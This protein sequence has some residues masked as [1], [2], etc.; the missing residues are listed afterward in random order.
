MAI[1]ATAVN[2]VSE[3]RRTSRSWTVIRKLWN[4]FYPPKNR[5]QFWSHGIFLCSQLTQTISKVHN[6]CINYDL[7]SHRYSISLE[8][9]YDLIKSRYMAKKNELFTLAIQQHRLSKTPKLSGGSRN[10]FSFFE[11]EGAGLLKMPGE[12]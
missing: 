5:I 6:D 11:G 1:K 12:S 9:N 2:D 10:C 4:H 3:R 7:I 8:D